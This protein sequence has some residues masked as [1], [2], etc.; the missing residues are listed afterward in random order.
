MKKIIPFI[1]LL[2]IV[3]P[4]KNVK[5]DPLVKSFTACSALDE[6]VEADLNEIASF[7]Q[8][9]NMDHLKKRL[10]NEVLLSFDHLQKEL[11]MLESYTCL[12]TENAEEGAKQ[13]L[14]IYVSMLNYFQEMLEEEE[15]APKVNELSLE[16]TGA[17]Y[18]YHLTA[19][20]DDRKELEITY[21]TGSMA[22][23]KFSEVRIEKLKDAYENDMLRWLVFIKTNIVDPLGS[24][25]LENP[26]GR[27]MQHVKQQEQQKADENWEKELQRALTG[28]SMLNMEFAIVEGDE[29]QY[30]T[31]DLYPRTYTYQLLDR[32]TEVYE[33]NPNI[34]YPKKDIQNENWIEIG[35]FL[36]GSQLEMDEYGRELYRYISDGELPS[37]H[38]VEDVANGKK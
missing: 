22:A 17:D 31:V 25:V 21:F 30:R 9:G 8:S 29:N 26:I 15:E 38:T 20:F 24:L 16:I 4:C 19:T 34:P 5:A 37:T 28:S 14:E 18:L 11:E 33:I 13:K 32:W 35:D 6:Q 23:V 12:D 7:F 2:L 36:L 3:F 27:A 10:N 1:F